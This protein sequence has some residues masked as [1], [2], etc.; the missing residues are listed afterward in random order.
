MPQLDR[1]IANIACGPKHREIARAQISRTSVNST[2]RA[3]DPVDMDPDNG[4]M[5][6]IYSVTLGI[7][8]APRDFGVAEKFDGDT[9]SLIC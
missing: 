9:S 3:L 8:S 2:Q 4:A 1:L 5:R 7:A 6:A